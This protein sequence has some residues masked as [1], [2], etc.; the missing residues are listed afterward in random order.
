MAVFTAIGLVLQIIENALPVFTSVPGGKLGL[1][2]VTAILSILLFGWPSAMAISGL[3]AILGCLLA[4][5]V[6]ALPYSL[7]GA[8]LST[9]TMSLAM[10]KAGKVFSLIGT[11][12]IGA[13][14][15]NTAQIFVFSLM[16]GSGYIWSYLPVLC[17]LS[18]F[19]GGLTGAC[20]EF[21]KRHFQQMRF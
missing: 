2:N 14:V 9:A 18:I 15:H 13:A 7:A 12:I 17:L 20:A 1:A 3:R 5:G 4:G 10:K 11:G 8:L 16:A 21:A 6:S 19:S